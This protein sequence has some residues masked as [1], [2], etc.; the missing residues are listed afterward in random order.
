MFGQGNAV[1][2]MLN[3]STADATHDDPTIR[4]C[5]GF[6]KREGCETLSVV[7]L[8]PFR[9]SHPDLALNHHETP[10]WA[11]QANIDYIVAECHSAK[12][13]IAAYGSHKLAQKSMT[14]LVQSLMPYVK[15]LGFTKD[16]A[17]RHPLYVKADTPLEAMR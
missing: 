5:K 11:I 2:L 16:G 7:N 12:V 1:F 15:S 3:P 6:A 8:C 14:P 10:D 9:S 13:V 17:P 4:R